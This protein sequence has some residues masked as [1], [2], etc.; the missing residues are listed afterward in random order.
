VIRNVAIGTGVILVCVTVSIVSGGLG[1]PAVSMIFAVSAKTATSVALFDGVA[2]GVMAGV[3]TGYQTGDFDEALKAGAVA[4]SEGF[5]W[6]AIGGAVSG[7]YVE[8]KGL[9]GTACITHMT[10]NDVAKIQRDS[11][12]PLDF[13]CNFHSV[14]EYH[15]YKSAGLIPKK[16]NGKWAYTQNIDWNLKDSNGITNAERVMKKGLAP[17]DSNGNPFELHHIGQKT[18][19]PLAILTQDQH[20]GTGNFSKLHFNTGNGTGGVD[21]GSDWN[22]QKQQFWIDLYEMTVK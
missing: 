18:D 5:M 13:I 22:K 3:I 21:H 4:A 6:G 2:S 12:L 1:A 15:V 10:L 17:V 19:S 9:R 11:K 20:R 14:D 7:G 16:V 8:Y